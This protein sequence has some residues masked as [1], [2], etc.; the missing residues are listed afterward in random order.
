MFFFCLG[1]RPFMLHR[2]QNFVWSDLLFLERTTSNFLIPYFIQFEI[3]N[4]FFKL[5]S[6][7]W[8]A[9]VLSWMTNCNRLLVSQYFLFSESQNSGGLKPF[10]T[11]SPSSNGLS[12]IVFGSS[13]CHPLNSLIGFYKQCEK[14]PLGTHQES[15]KVDKELEIAKVP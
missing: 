15:R 10:S 6:V 3:C 1:Q 7:F 14:I 4:I 11:S 13:I 8:G 2:D 9:S 5:K 12:D